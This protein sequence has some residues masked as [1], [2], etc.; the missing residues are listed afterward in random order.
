LLSVSYQ[1]RQLQSLYSLFE[2]KNKYRQAMLLS[3]TDSQNELDSPQLLPHAYFIRYFRS[4]MTYLTQIRYSKIVKI[5][6]GI[7]KE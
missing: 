5:D 4:N 6:H 1:L 7:P 3:T 2:F